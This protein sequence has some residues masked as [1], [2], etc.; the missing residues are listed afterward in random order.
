ME[1][2]APRKLPKD[3]EI[4]VYCASFECRASPAAARKLE[5]LG[6]TRVLEYEGGLA[7]WRDAGYPLESAKGEP[8]SR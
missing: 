4:V 8:A 5:E 7:D 1:A 6:Y 2:E 3:K